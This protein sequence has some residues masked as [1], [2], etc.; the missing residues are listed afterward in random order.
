MGSGGMGGGLSPPGSFEYEGRAPSVTT[1]RQRLGSAYESNFGCE[2]VF[3]LQSPEDLMQRLF[4]RGL[5]WT[6]DGL[7]SCRPR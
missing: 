1:E 5:L 7:P 6:G 3:V 4:W 2:R